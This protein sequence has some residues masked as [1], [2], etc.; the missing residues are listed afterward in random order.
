MHKEIASGAK[1]DRPV[2]NKIIEDLRPED[3]LV[4][5]KLDRL[6]RSL[7]HLVTLVNDLLSKKISIISINDL[8]DTSSV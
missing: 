6:G 5:W 2:L 4:I 8:I 7:R 3:T 1:S